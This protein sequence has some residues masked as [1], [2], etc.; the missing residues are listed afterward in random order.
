MA[1]D[2]N[3]SFVKQ[4]ESEVH[5][6]YQQMGSKFR[7]T[8]RTKNGIVGESTTFQ[9]VGKGAASTKARHGE[10]TPMTIDHTP[11]TCTLADW[12]AGDYVDKLDE[13]KINHDERRVIVN[14]G[15]Y[16]LGRKTDELI[17]AQAE[18][19]TN[20]TPAASGLDLDAVL[21]A[22]ESLGSRDAFEGGGGL[23]AFVGW[24]Q[25]ADLM[26]IEDFKDA[27]R[28][29]G[30]DLPFKQTGVKGRK[31]LDT[32]WMPH[33]GLTLDTAERQCLW[34]NST[35]LG[36]AIGADVSTDIDWEGRKAA[37]FVN[38]MMSQGACLID[39]SG[40]EMLDVTES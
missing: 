23:Y 15:A 25:W 13:L 28:I 12:Y 38:N 35:A 37:H 8:V 16:A 24:K 30:E 3:D 6:V 40:V 36:H 9:K 32:V 7:N 4:Y 1:M 39:E 18:T 34:Y 27:D 22:L 14:A 31:W 21:A 2:I 29:G 11:V 26:K 5:E 19:T 10:I 33:T 20:I 17:I